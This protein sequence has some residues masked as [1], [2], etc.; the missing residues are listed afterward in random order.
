MAMF[1]HFRFT[2]GPRRAK[3]ALM[4]LERTR[5]DFLTWLAAVPAVGAVGCAVDHNDGHDDPQDDIP[6]T[7]PVET[8]EEGWTTCRLTSRDA[9]G[10]Y[11]EPGSPI[12]TTARIASLSEPGTRLIVEGRLF[13]R[14]CRTLLKGYALDVWQA[15]DDGNYYDAAASSY[16]LRGKVL[17]DSLGRYRIE[18]ILPGRY[19]D[20]A[21]IRPAHIH[22]R[23]L[24]PGGNVLLT[25]QLYFAGD[26][27]LGQADYCTRDGTCNSS[28]PARAL[29]L[30]DAIVNGKA[31]KKASFDAFLP[32]T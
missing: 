28:D 17:T 26:P 31:G 24:T 16:R 4:N 22:V 15:D 14:D 18:T 21:G 6:A 2:K 20:S 19:G 30:R 10:P 9:T 27:Y 32:R 7:E 1:D 3:T 12:R 8:A 5:R 23:M 13:G 29:A 11:F 25:T